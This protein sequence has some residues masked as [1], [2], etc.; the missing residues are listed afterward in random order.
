MKQTSEEI[1]YKQDKGKQ[2]G[3]DASDLTTP[4]TISTSNDSNECKQALTA[5]KTNA[6]A[7]HIPAGQSVCRPPPKRFCNQ[8]KSGRE[9]I[10]IERLT[11]KQ[12]MAERRKKVRTSY[13]YFFADQHNICFL[14]K[15]MGGV[16]R[17]EA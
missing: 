16:Q 7:F 6:V 15:S 8:T 13:C 11:E 14:S 4:D 10:S 17:H 12:N 5:S 1:S 9:N 2:K 3:S